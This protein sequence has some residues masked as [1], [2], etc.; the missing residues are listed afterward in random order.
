MKTVWGFLILACCMGAPCAFADTASGALPALQDQDAR[1]QPQMATA[2]AEEYPDLPPTRRPQ[3][4]GFAHSGDPYDIPDFSHEEM[5]G[6]IKNYGG[7]YYRPHIPLKEALPEIDQEHLRRLK[8]AVYNPDELD[9]L[10]EEL[11]R[12]GKWDRIDALVDAFTS[13]GVKLI[14]VVGCGYQKEAPLIKKADGKTVKVSPSAMGKELYLTLAKWYVGAAARRYAS[15]VQVWQVENEINSAL[16]HVIGK[17][18]TKDPAWASR[19]YGIEMLKALSE[20]VHKEGA[21]QGFAL[22][23]TQNFSTAKPGW[24]KYIRDSAKYVDIV[25]IDLY[26]NYFF[27]FQPADRKMADCVLKAKAVSG[28][29]PVWVLEAGFADGPSQRGF[30]PQAQAIYFKRLIDRCFRNG[31][32]VV[33]VFGWFWNP[34]G[35]YTN[36]GKPAPWYSPMAT[37][38]HWS[39]TSKDPKTGKISFGPAWDEFKKAAEK[40]LN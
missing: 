32:D 30:T 18:R 12:N 7:S 8:L 22:K 38:A 31:A 23:T 24:E 14:L 6:I 40:W 2:L 33:L 10:T 11:A 36:S 13:G 28:G 4:L 3:G 17:W 29:K 27:G 20:V 5:A 1:Y 34:T 35:W 15:K 26:A 16:F 19:S 37:E 21:R 39:P 9:S 25:G